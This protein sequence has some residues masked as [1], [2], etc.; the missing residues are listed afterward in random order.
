MYDTLK[1]YLRQDSVRDTDLMAEIPVYLEDITAHEDDTGI[2]YSGALNNLRIHVSERGVSI[3]GSLAK[4]YLSDNLKTMRRKDTEQA[5]QKLSDELHL[6]IQD[7]E[8][9]RV[10]FAHNFIMDYEP[11]VYYQYLG[12]CQYFE[13]F[14]QP[15]SLYY[16]NKSRTLLFYDKPAEAKSKGCKI[17]ET[18]TGKHV[19]RYEIRYRRRLSNQLKVPEVRARTLYEE[20]FYIKLVDRYVSDYQSIHKTAEIIFDTINMNTP[21]DVKDQLALIGLMAIGQNRFPELVEEWRAKDVLKKPEYYSRIKRDM[22]ELAEKFQA[23]DST[24]MIDEL[25]SKISK[26]KRYYR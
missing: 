25:D 1:L 15:K 20:P 8:V 26:L 21:K 12:E 9:F 7:A 10:D 19:L 14:L 22:R 5:M 24:P 16:S 2:S 11:K 23:S 18:W 17:P 13:R 4:Y 6:S 3:K